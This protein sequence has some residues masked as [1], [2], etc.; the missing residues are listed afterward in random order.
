MDS[1]GVQRSDLPAFADGTEKEKRAWATKPMSADSDRLQAAKL[2]VP[3]L[4]DR[5]Y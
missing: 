2:P 3:R 4:R 1:I 5:R